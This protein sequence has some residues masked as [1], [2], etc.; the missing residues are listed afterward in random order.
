MNSGTPAINAGP[1]LSAGGNRT[2][3]E[4]IAPQPSVRGTLAGWF[5]PLTIAVATERIASE[6]PRVGQVVQSF[7]EVKTSGMV[8]P[9][10]GESLEIKQGG[11]RSWKTAVLHVYRQ[12]DVPTDT[13]IKVKGV[14][15][16]VTKKQDFE[17]N[18]YIRYEL[19]QDYVAAA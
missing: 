9:G 15:Y 5:R 18:G 6:G 8:Q 3:A 7:H 1:V 13:L 12:L 10:E 19:L 11:E 2:I 16:R 17:A 14:S 4:C